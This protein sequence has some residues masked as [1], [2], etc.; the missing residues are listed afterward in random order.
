M[1][2]EIRYTRA[3]DGV[4]IAYCAVGNGPALI[5]LPAPP[6]G[7][8]EMTWRIAEWRDELT[9][10]SQ[11]TTFI[12]YDPRGFGMS[13]R[14]ITD[15]SLEAM[16]LDL[17]AVVDALSIDRFAVYAWTEMSMIVLTYAARHPERVSGLALREGIAQ[18]SR[19]KWFDEATKQARDN[20]ALYKRMLADSTG[21][22]RT[23]SGLAQVHDM[24]E[25][26]ATQDNYVRYLEQTRT[27]DARDV[28]S[29]VVAP[30]LV[31]NDGS[32]PKEDGRVLAAA[33]PRGS[34]VANTPAR[35]E[36]SPSAAA[37]LE[38]LARALAGES[39]AAS[40]SATAKPSDGRFAAT[41]TT[42]EIEILR[43]VVAGK[44]SRE[45]A[46]GLVLSPRTVERH[47]ANI[48]R[49]TETHGRAQLAAFAVRHNVG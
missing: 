39:S 5:N 22:V 20:W 15:F 18:G 40:S 10:A 43:L 31:T 27:W 9:A 41:L 32:V 48:Y 28:L 25:H 44:S 38:F 37:I 21:N 34:F 33:L 49:K 45:I 36:A 2:P 47:I 19:I 12:Q 8:V 4:S 3:A 16:V 6:F 30:V 17:E 26:T 23:V 13:E 24:I 46:E 42:R 29:A 35:G 1:A 14:D 7:N 11:R